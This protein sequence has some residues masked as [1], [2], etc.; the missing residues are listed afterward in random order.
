M[1][2]EQL[3]IR[4]SSIQECACELSDALAGLSRGEA[5]LICWVMAD[6]VAIEHAHGEEAALARVE[7]FE[8]K[9]RALKFSH[10][11]PARE[12]SNHV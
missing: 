5:W 9:L 2:D 7:H 3:W 11:P 1:S 12:R 10:H 8:A 6:I 4:Q